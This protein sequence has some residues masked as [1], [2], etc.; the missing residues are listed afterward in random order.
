MPRRLQL[1]LLLGASLARTGTSGWMRNT[2]SSE[3]GSIVVAHSGENLACAN[4]A[5][6]AVDGQA[7]F[8]CP[9]A[10]GCPAE[11]CPI[12]GWNAGTD[13]TL[14]WLV[15]DF[16]RPITLSS[17]RFSGAGD[18]MH[19]PKDMQVYASA[20]VS[21][22][23]REV[24]DPMVASAGKHGQNTFNAVWQQFSFPPTASRYWK[25]EIKSRHGGYQAWVGEV[26]F[27]RAESAWGW[28][29]AAALL[30][31][32]L[33][34]VGGGIVWGRR[35]LGRGGGLNA[36]PHRHRWAELHGLVLD[37]MGW[38]QWRLLGR[39]GRGGA[40]QY[41]PLTKGAAA[42]EVNCGGRS[43]SPRSS[44]KVKGESPGAKKKRRKGKA[45]KKLSRSRSEATED[46]GGEGGSWPSPA[47]LAT[48]A[49]AAAPA[50]RE[51]RPTRSMHLS[52][53]ARETGVKV[54]DI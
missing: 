8:G 12:L 45:G 3:M 5:W 51:W 42:R 4:N 49:A 16:K 31:G 28:A 53:G 1:Q 11:Q 2:A 43:A 38:A 17:L 29:V 52:S 24:G 22:P 46:S 23:W 41:V 33:L 21:G 15:F 20:A 7:G 6:K 18:A 27:Y 30:G 48:H 40:G 36:H 44:V 35:Y 32:G 47:P 39:R 37:G 54:A 19:D 10:T 34:Y 26:E 25:W 13:N 9:A 50:G 14:E